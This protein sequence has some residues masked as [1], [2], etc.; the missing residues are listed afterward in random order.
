MLENVKHILIFWVK[1]PNCMYR[2]IEKNIHR[3]TITFNDETNLIIV[4]IN[5]Q[6]AMII[7]CYVNRV[8]KMSIDLHSIQRMQCNEIVTNQ[9]KSELNQ[10]FSPGIE[11]PL[12]IS[13][14]K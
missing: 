8:K 5:V 11:S 13:M 4:Q 2:Y 6:V 9:I 10:L 12:T 1:S 3:K 7:S 14:S